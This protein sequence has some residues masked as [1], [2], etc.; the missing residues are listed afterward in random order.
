MSQSKE[1]DKIWEKELSKIEIGNLTTKEF[2]V[3]VIKV[4]MELKRRMGKHSENLNR[5]KIKESTKWKL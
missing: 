4:L 1:Q 3:R 2:E 5:E